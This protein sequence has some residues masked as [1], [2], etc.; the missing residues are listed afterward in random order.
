MYQ[1]KLEQFQGPLEL[2][3]EI[4]EKQELDI[5]QVSLAKIAEDYLVYIKQAE[6]PPDEMAD[7]LLV[8]SKLLFIKSQALFP[9][10]GLEEEGLALEIQLKILKLYFD[11]SKQIDQKIREKQFVYFRD[12]MPTERVFRPPQKATVTVLQSAFEAVIKAVM[13]LV[14]VPKEIKIRMIS[15][16][17]RIEHMKKMILE[18]LTMSFKGF[19]GQSKDKTELIVSFLALLELCKQRVVE[20]KQ[21]GLFKDILIERKGN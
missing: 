4:I 12:K 5:T 11:A 15:I 6:L 20:V 8:A 13:P 18:K 2:L 7:F 17:E 10:F 9:Q 3:L 19:T 16:G 21:E 14:R 1:I